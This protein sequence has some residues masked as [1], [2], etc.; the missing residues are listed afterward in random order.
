[1]EAKCSSETSVDTRRTTRRH[2]PD[3]DTLHNHRSE[4]L[5]SYDPLLFLLHQSVLELPQSRFKINS[6]KYESYKQL[7]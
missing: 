3:D 5:K 6:R 4:N 2:I 1:M 7:V